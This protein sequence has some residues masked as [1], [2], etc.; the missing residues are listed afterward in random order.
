MP[1]FTMKDYLFLSWKD[2]DLDGIMGTNTKTTGGI[3]SS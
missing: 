2:T 3:T 1:S